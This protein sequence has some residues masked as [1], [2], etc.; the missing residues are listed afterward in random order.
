MSPMPNSQAALSALIETFTHPMVVMRQTGLELWLA[1]E[2]YLRLVGLP[3]KH[4]EGR[5]FLDFVNPE[6]RSR[7]AIRLQMHFEGR[8]PAPNRAIWRLLP[9]AD[10]KTHDT[11]TFSQELRFENGE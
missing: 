1:N 8:N 7:M 11:A 4:V 6:E 3:R 9:S 10:G 2:A 5:P